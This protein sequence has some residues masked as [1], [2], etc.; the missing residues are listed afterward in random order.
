MEH[1]A[2]RAARW[3]VE[4][5]YVDAAG[6]RQIVPDE[7]LRTVLDALSTSGPPPEPGLLPRTIVVRKGH[8]ARLDLARRPA[9]APVRWRVM[10]DTTVIAQGGSPVRDCCL[11]SDLPVGTFR[12]EVTIRGLR[13]ERADTVL[14]VTPARAYQGEDAGSRMWA[15]AVQLYG[16]RSHRNWGHG[17]FGDL[18]RL[19]DLAAGIGAAGI[20]LNPL[21]ALFDDRPEQASPYSPNSR[22][23]LN[24]LYIDIEA[25][26][27]FPGREAAGL[28]ERIERARRGDRV[29]Y[30]GVAEAKIAALRLTYDRFRAAPDPQRRSDFDAFR[31][32][33][34][35]QLARFASFEVLRRR[36]PGP[37]WDWPDPWRRPS[38]AALD[39]LRRS[40][41]EAI[42]FH[43]FVQWIADRQLAA[44]Q[45]QARRLNLP[46][47]LYIDLAVGVDAGGADAW[48]DQEDF[49]L[50][51]SI[52]APPDPLNMEGQNWGLATFGPHRLEADAFAPFRR[53]IAA[54]MRHA[55][56]IRLDHVLG[57]ERMFLVPHGSPAREGAYLRFP[58]EA[59]LAVVAQESTDKRCLVIGEDL[60]TVP[61]DFRAIMAGWG[62]WSYRVLTFERNR[63]GAFLAP[64]HYPRDAL[65]SFGTHDLA[66]FAGW[67]S[68]R[69]LAV[70]RALGLDP[71]ETD[72]E[73]E[74]ARAALAA[75]LERAG[76]GS[77]CD[78]A[79][80]TR[81]L[82]RT[83]S[84][85]VVVTIE[86]ALGVIDQPNLP[87]TVDEHPNWR[88]RLP[89]A[90]EDWADRLH[91]L[92]R[93]FAEEGRSAG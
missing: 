66:T 44:C 16:L 70:K 53:T 54:A 2:D 42:G 65:A 56:A 36:F 77:T 30:T 76:L 19:I 9:H 72:E 63:D 74:R 47:G 82:A 84:R 43:E 32:E 51:L 25:V 11:P 27:E 91:A 5:D 48:S 85:L 46:I 17:D 90:L 3:G 8:P 38:A 4:T 81:F 40:D 50:S 86:D 80:V 58:L 33:K 45:D 10:A 64:A 34:G 21:H 61:A 7:A 28:S 52:G 67:M 68:G 79:A 26:P 88:Q 18:A 93:L 29:D 22:I 13:E 60:G 14:L 35:T 89:V 1:L 83:P 12:L 87:G 62:I 41:G 71:G 39:D 55:G 37:W 49:L 59:M 78:F 57:L 20:G 92:G 15:L 69:D 24:P 31:H 6:R 73:R 75:A 23:F